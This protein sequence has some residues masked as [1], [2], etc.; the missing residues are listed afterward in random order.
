MGA[1]ARIDLMD[2]LEAVL[3]RVNRAEEAR[4]ILGVMARI[5]GAA[6]AAVF[7]ERRGVLRWLAGDR[8]SEDATAAIRT[9]WWA[10]RRRVLSGA[11]FSDAPDME[12]AE[13]PAWVMWLRRPRDGGLDAVYFA[14]PR[15]RP[16]E[17]CASRLDRLG[18]LLMRLQ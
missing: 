18:A 9:A 4:Q 14:G 11:A 17:Q 5:C 15:L 12:T 10:Q 3:P 16:L 7:F 1:M 2:R 6:S 8:L 13:M